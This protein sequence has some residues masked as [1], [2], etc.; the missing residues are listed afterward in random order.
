MEHFDAY[1]LVGYTADSHTKVVDANF[2]QDASCQDGLRILQAAAEQW[3]DG[4]MFPSFKKRRIS[5][6]DDDTGMNGKGA[7]R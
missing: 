5:G 3:M 4:S 6:Q 7:K 1:I 2:G